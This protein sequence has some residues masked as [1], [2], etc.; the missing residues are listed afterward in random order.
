[1]NLNKNKPDPFGMSWYFEQGEIHCKLPPPINIIPNTASTSPFSGADND[2]SA[3]KF[4]S[5][6]EDVVKGLSVTED[7][8][9][10]SFI[11]SRLVPGSRAL[12]LMQSSDF[13]LTD[14]GTDCELFKR[15]FL[16]V[17]GD[18]G[19]ESLAKQVSHPVDTL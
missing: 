12:N 1:M 7:A 8:G 9:N 13:S 16:K 18:S 17:F 19:R 5:L 3:R 4:N 2:F 6:C 10:I 14:I 11:R 15:N